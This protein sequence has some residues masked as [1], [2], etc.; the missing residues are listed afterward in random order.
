ME[1]LG[2]QRTKELDLVV[3]LQFSMEYYK[4]AMKQEVELLDSVAG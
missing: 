4:I 3:E 2:D 1:Q